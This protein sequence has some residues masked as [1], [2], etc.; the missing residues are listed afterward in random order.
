MINERREKLKNS[1][2]IKFLFQ[3]MRIQLHKI[4]FHLIYLMFLR[5]KNCLLILRYFRNH[6]FQTIFI[7]YIEIN[8]YI[9]I[10]IYVI[11]IF[12]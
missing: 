6:F 9:Y 2:L 8:I 7:I 3:R 1:T 4:K 11:Y 10:R 5:C 12:N